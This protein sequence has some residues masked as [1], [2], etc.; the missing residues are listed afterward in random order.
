[1]AEIQGLEALMRKLKTLEN[2]QKV[3]DAPMREAVMVLR[4]DW[5]KYPPVPAGSKYVRTGRLYGGWNSVTKP[6]SS[7]I[8]G[9]VFNRGVYYA[10]FVQDDGKQRWFHAKTGWRTQSTTLDAKTKE[11]VKIFEDVVSRELKK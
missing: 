9:T 7:G 3:L 1:M 10:P 8:S 5:T 6:M 11:I 4:Q 2:F